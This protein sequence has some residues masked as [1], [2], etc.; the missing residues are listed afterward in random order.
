MAAAAEDFC[1]AWVRVLLVVLL[2]VSSL[3]CMLFLSARL[4]SLFV[5]LAVSHRQNV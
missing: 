3:S 2:V 4:S 5:L 1:L